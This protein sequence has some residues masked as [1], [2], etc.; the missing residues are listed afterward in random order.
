MKIS[1]QLDVLCNGDAVGLHSAPTPA[2]PDNHYN[3]HSLSHSMPELDCK[4]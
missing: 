3:L 2:G 1:F 4:V